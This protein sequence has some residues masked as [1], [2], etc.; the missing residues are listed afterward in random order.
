MMTS[1]KNI[2]KDMSLCQIIDTLIQD[3]T[4]TSL[5]FYSYFEFYL[6]T[7]R[8]YN[9]LPKKNNRI[10]ASNGLFAINSNC[11]PDSLEADLCR[12]NEIFRALF[13]DSTDRG[14]ND[15]SKYLTESTRD[16]LAVLRKQVT[17]LSNIF[18]ETHQ[19]TKD[20]RIKQICIIALK[21]I[22]KDVASTLNNNLRAKL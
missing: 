12:L 14:E 5:A 3:K 18:T 10:T 6:V 1:D 4:I 17:L 22:D 2:F 8:I 13:T 11:F 19:T 16:Q 21:R 9:V 15:H 20:E 7:Q